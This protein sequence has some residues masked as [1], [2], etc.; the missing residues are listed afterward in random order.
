VSITPID[1]V[2]GVIDG[3]VDFLTGFLERTFVAGRDGRDGAGEQKPNK[4]QFPSFHSAS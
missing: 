2:S 4:G 1:G 3:I